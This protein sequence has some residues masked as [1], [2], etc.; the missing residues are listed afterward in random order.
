MGLLTKRIQEGFWGGKPEKWE[1]DRVIPT[2]TDEQLEFFKYN[3]YVYLTDQRG[4]QWKMHRGHWNYEQWEA[5]YDGKTF[6]DF[7][8]DSKEN[9][10]NCC[11]KKV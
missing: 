9:L 7:M 4:G 1:D 3:K 11:G 8:G 6:F 5:D 2:V 10:C